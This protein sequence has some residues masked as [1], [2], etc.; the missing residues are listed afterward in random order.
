MVAHVLHQ[1]TYYQFVSAT[2]QRSGD[3]VIV[4]KSHG[5]DRITIQFEDGTKRA[6]SWNSLRTPSPVEHLMVEIRRSQAFR[7]REG[8]ESGD[9]DASEAYEDAMEELT[10]V[11]A[12]VLRL[13][14]VIRRNHETALARI[15]QNDYASPTDAR[16]DP[17]GRT[18]SSRRTAN[19][20]RSND[21]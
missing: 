15:R 19:A 3:F 20:R 10:E 1:G 8:Y 12:R 2:S 14:D 6:S 7:D 21:P 5:N 16:T 18:R 9:S 13:E 4:T 17:R 11:L